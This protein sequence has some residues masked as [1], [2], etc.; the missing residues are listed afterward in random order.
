M[1]FSKN[2][3]KTVKQSELKDLFK[4]SEFK[5]LVLVVL[6]LL[7]VFGL[8][9]VLI[10]DS[11]LLDLLAFLYLSG[12]TAVLLGFVC[13]FVNKP[14]PQLYKKSELSGENVWNDCDKNN[15]NHAVMETL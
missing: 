5:D 11:G 15:K 9:S 2:Y 6:G 3:K 14:K 8:S 13:N 1:D 4:Q 7:V 10:E 12:L